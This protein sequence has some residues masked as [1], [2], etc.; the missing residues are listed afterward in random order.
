MSDK[1]RTQQAEALPAGNGPRRHR[2]WRRAIVALLCT[3]G[4]LIIL[5]V[6]IVAILAIATAWLTPDRLSRIIS[7]ELSSRLDADV[8]IGKVHFTIWSSF[9]M[10]CVETD[11]LSITSHALDSLPEAIRR[12]L[13]ADASL[14]L[15]AGK[16]SG[17]VNVC[18]LLD[19]KIS[20]GDV[21]ADSLQVNLCKAST[22]AANWMI[23]KTREK[24]EAI[25]EFT[26]EQLTL[27]HAREIRYR[28]LTSGADILV[29]PDSVAIDRVGYRQI[30]DLTLTGNISAGAGEKQ[31][32]SRLPFSLSGETALHFSPMRMSAKDFDV[33]AGPLHGSVDL[34]MTLEKKFTIN[35]FRYRLDR[36]GIPELLKMLPAGIIPKGLLASIPLKEGASSL[37]AT[38]ALQQPYTPAPGESPLFSLV[39][40]VFGDD[41]EISGTVND[42]GGTPEVRATVRGKVPLK[43]MAALVPELK[44]IGISGRMTADIGVRFRVTDIRDAAIRDLSLSG[45]AEVKDFG[46]GR[47]G[48]YGR[49][50][51][52][53]VRLDFNAAT[54]GL[55][56]RARRAAGNLDGS[57]RL[58]ASG[59]ALSYPA[60]SLHMNID[61]TDMDLRLTAAGDFSPRKIGLAITNAGVRYRQ[62]NTKFRVSSLATTA[63]VTKR[64][65]PRA[66]PSYAEPAAWNADD[67]EVSMAGGVSRRTVAPHVSPKF[68]SLLAN[69]DV[70]AHTSGAGCGFTTPAYPLANRVDRLDITTDGDSVTIH[71]LRASSGRS[72]ATISG[73]VTNLRQF[74]ISGSPAPLRA[75]I[76]ARFDRLDVNDIAAGYEQ[77]VINTRG[78]AA[79]Q[80]MLSQSGVLPSDTIARMIPRNIFVDFRA[81]AREFICTDIVAR[82]L[83]GSIHMGDGN[84]RLDSLT[85]RTGFATAVAGLSYSTASLPTMNIGAYCDLDSL[86]LER[87]F[88]RFPSLVE[89]APQLDNLSGDVAAKVNFNTGLFPTMYMLMPSMTADFDVHAYR[90][91]L[92]KTGIIRKVA[93]LM[94]LHGDEPVHFHDIDIH[95]ALYD[96]LLMVDPFT[97]AFADYKVLVG[98]LNNLHGDMYYH[99]GLLDWPLKIKAGVNLKGDFDH[100]E[101]RLGRSS[102][103]DAGP[104][105]LRRGITASAPVNI[106][107]KLRHGF[108]IF[109][110]TAAGYAK[111]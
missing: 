35:T 106:A 50:C 76:T 9:P 29:I 21:S 72:A 83:T 63:S 38:A 101:V 47:L 45:T 82:D 71:E 34:D 24:P 1:E 77:G 67:L 81:S 69:W 102:W 56:V 16:I 2:P 107:S 17:S 85:L 92:R 97:V 31:Y 49:I 98:G 7:K 108:L 37:S 88:A 104:S 5:I 73:S 99:I 54:K 59:I 46:L 8:T 61:R 91:H 42:L 18:N 41:L 75:D 86:S 48:Q 25:P 13:P 109:L 30:Y 14:L 43:Q 95:G 51:I 40:D 12:R 36:V 3:I 62:G 78:A 103:H 57:A 19:K 111:K 94:M 23:A 58:H 65:T 68:R 89:K 60:D 39:L 70:R 6:A 10:L 96:N 90:L 28:D 33:S 93:H 80:R 84:A 44:E 87:F 27:I 4:G 15:C 79:L 20:V 100:P 32:V 55:D 11:S 110:H 53:N 52:G 22:E 105:Q 64:G 26:L 66:I 74:I